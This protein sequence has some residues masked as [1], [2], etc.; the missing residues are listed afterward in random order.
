MGAARLVL[1]SSPSTAEP[2][3]EWSSMVLSLE[4]WGGEAGFRI[5]SLSI[6]TVF[7]LRGAKKKKKSEKKLQTFIGKTEFLQDIYI[8]KR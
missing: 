4:E 5:V 1:Q 3:M 8:R 2:M 7:L 6:Y